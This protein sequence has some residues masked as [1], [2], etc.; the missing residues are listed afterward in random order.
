MGQQLLAKKKRRN[1]GE[2][3]DYS[4]YVPE[5]NLLKNF[6]T[7]MSS[8]FAYPKQESKDLADWQALRP[9]QNYHL[10]V[11]KHHLLSNRIGMSEELKKDILLDCL[12]TQD[13]NFLAHYRGL[14]VTEMLHHL[15]ILQPTSFQP[16]KHKP[17]HEESPQLTD[18]E[19]KRRVQ[20]G[21][22]L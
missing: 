11:Q 9:D 8:C 15:T 2:K 16:S 18:K 12:E 20:T 5:T 6:L 3:K 21:S 19:Y 13:R 1:Q 4:N 22:H 14:S 17:T 7:Y 10:L